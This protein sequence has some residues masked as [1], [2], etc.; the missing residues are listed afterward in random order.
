MS[1]TFSTHFLL[2]FLKSVSNQME[3]KFGGWREYYSSLYFVFVFCFSHKCNISLDSA[4]RFV[5]ILTSRKS[6]RV[7]LSTVNH[8]LY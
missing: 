8:I 6:L 5:C 4:H 2:H 7:G 3:I 1:L